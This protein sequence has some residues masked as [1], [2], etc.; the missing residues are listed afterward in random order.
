M[1]SL[2]TAYHITT[3]FDSRSFTEIGTRC[4]NTKRRLSRSIDSVAFFILF[5][6]LRTRPCLC[7]DL[8]ESL[9]EL[10]LLARSGILVHDVVRN[11]LIDLL[12]GSLVCNCGSSLVSG[13]ACSVKLLLASAI[14]TRFFA[15]LIFGILV[16]LLFK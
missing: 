6:F 5:Y 8:V 7:T 2:R 13:L 4:G 10:A 16:S 12:Y 11:C 1:R 9:G 15:D 3:R 14:F